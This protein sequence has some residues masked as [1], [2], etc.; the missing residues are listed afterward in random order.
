MK[1]LKPE[2]TKGGTKMFARTY[3]V[4]FIAG[5]LL[6]AGCDNPQLPGGYSSVSTFS[7]DV[8]DAA[9]FAVDEQSKVNSGLTLK[10]IESAKS[11]VVAGTNVELMLSVIDGG[12]TKTA[13]AV[14]YTDLN[15]T[16][17]LTSWDWL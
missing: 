10:S 1:F 3:V 12:K 4:I 6:S 11:Q 17:S 8:T 5:V 16:R 2:K 15:Q 14:V 13:R 7:Q 9:E